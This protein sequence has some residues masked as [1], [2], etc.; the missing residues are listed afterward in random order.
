MTSGRWFQGHTCA[1]SSLLFLSLRGG[2][3]L[4]FD[5]SRLDM[6]LFHFTFRC[7]NLVQLHWSI[8]LV[9]LHQTED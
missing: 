5:G 7:Y 8:A 1:P 9:F 6:A 2:G 3:T 4:L